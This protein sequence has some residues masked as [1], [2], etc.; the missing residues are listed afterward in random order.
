MAIWLVKIVVDCHFQLY[1][2][3][4][5][6][7]INNSQFYTKYNLPMSAQDLKNLSRSV[8]IDVST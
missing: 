5:A 7:V 6:K 4:E 1:D 3:Y 2:L 8:A